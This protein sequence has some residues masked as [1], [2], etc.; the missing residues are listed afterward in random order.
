MYLPPDIEHQDWDGRMNLAG[1][2]VQ[3]S[4]V[5][6]PGLNTAERREFLVRYVC[7]HNT[8]SQERDNYRNAVDQPKSIS[9]RTPQ[10]Y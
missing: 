3:C 9:R 4:Y 10:H 6:R 1:K 5:S 7:I 2:T 8:A